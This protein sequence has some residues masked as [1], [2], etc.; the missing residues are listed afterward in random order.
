MDAM[1]GL[2]ARSPRLGKK[3]IRT[4]TRVENDGADLRS[5]GCGGLVEAVK[6]SP[7]LVLCKS[8]EREI[9]VR[10]LKTNRPSERSAF[11]NESRWKESTTSGRRNAV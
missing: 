7:L 9:V 10:G 4:A 3:C 1:A 8:L 5:G 11:E 2:L 6:E